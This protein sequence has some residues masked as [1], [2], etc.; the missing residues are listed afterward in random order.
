MSEY[1]S[2]LSLEG[3][4]E[5]AGWSEVFAD[6]VSPS[7]YTDRLENIN[8]S[9]LLLTTSLELVCLL[10]LLVTMNNSLHISSAVSVRRY[11]NGTA[12]ASTVYISFQQ[13]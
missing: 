13:W 9:V 1:A 11:C 7:Q 6:V 5:V 12:Q 3:W 8:S 2:R 4:G 10:Q